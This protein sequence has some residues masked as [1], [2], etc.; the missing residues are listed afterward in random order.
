MGCLCIVEEGIIWKGFFGDK[1]L[2]VFTS[3]SFIIG[4]GVALYSVRLSLF[5]CVCLRMHTFPILHCTIR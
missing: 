3:L 2:P 5:L 4:F 1:L